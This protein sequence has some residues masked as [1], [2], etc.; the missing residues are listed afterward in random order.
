[1]KQLSY[2]EF[3]IKAKAELSGGEVT[4]KAQV[5]NIGKTAGKEVVRL[6]RASFRA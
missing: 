6:R 2:T 3:E 4:V 1:M 5:E